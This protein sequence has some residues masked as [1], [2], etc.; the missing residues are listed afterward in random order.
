MRRTVKLYKH[1][2]FEY[3][4][5]T[6]LD[7]DKVTV[8]PFYKVWDRKQSRIRT[9][10]KD[11]DSESLWCTIEYGLLWPYEGPNRRFFY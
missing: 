3:A 11:V 10:W 9:V 4:D 2:H 6:T 7:R 1:E 5:G 8:E